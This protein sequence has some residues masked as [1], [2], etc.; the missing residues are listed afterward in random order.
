MNNEF[1]KRVTQESGYW[2]SSIF[3]EFLT[4][5][6]HFNGIIYESVRAID[7]LLKNV[8]CVA[9]CPPFVDNYL[10]FQ[11][12]DLYSFDFKNLKTSI[13]LEKIKHFTLKDNK[14]IQEA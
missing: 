5:N 1:T 6:L 3:T 14:T 13:Q 9:L 8:H 7:P 2:I 10:K 11:C 12:A 4:H